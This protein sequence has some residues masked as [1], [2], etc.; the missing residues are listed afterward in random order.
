M[1][2]ALDLPKANSTFVV[3]K[4]L[5]VNGDESLSLQISPFGNKKPN[6]SNETYNVPTK[7]MNISKN[8][9]SNMMSEESPSHVRSNSPAKSMS[10]KKQRYD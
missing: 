6:K 5:M 8:M 1:D 7:A 2:I 9:G 4:K 10:S 3:D